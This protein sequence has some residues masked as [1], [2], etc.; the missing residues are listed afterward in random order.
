[1]TAVRRIMSVIIKGINPPMSNEEY[2]GNRTHYSSSQLKTLYWD[3]D[4]FH[5]EYILG[6]KEP[7][8]Q[9]DGLTEGTLIHT[10]ILEP[11]LYDDQ[12]A[13]SSEYTK[14]GNAY[15]DFVAANP[16]KLCISGGQAQKL[17]NMYAAYLKRPEAVQAIKQS[18]TEVTVGSEIMGIPVKIRC[19]AI[20]IEHG[21]I[22]DVKSTSY[23][24]DL[25][26]FKQNAYS[27]MLS[28]DISAALYCL[29]AEQELGR[30]F[31]FHYIVISKSEFRCEIYKSSQTSLIN[32]RNKI[33]KAL[34]R[35]NHFK[36]HGVWPT[37]AKKAAA[38]GNYE[39]K[40]L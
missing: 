13:V 2:H 33:F 3:Q 25:E 21:I 22:S 38:S 18:R 35:L 36:Q 37:G 34:E 14:R 12:V 11:H 5:R 30:P 23:S 19:D 31:D 28:Y 10:K 40:E 26:V 39:I 24:A 7:M 20:D 8:K 1:M 17:E 16:G 27:Q 6:E 9:T 15:K 4:K 29:V 32:G